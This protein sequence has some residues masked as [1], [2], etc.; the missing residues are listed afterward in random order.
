MRFFLR[1]SERRPDPKP[2]QTD[3]RKPVLIGLA[4]WLVALVVLILV[5]ALNTV[6]LFTVVTG[7][8]IGVIALGYTLV[9]RRKV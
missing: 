4:A 5:R 1:D 8:A 9:R 2:V 7:L 3:D 6:V